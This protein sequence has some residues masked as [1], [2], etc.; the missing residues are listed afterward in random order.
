MRYLWLTGRSAPNFPVDPD[1][2]LYVLYGLKTVYL[3]FD[4][5]GL[6]GQRCEE[7]LGGLYPK[8]KRIVV[9]KGT[10]SPKRLPLPD[11]VQRFTVA[12]EGG[13]YSTQFQA[14]QLEFFSHPR[15]IGHEQRTFVCRSRIQRDPSEVVANHYAGALLIPKRY[16]F[17]ILPSQPV[18]LARSGE[19]LCRTFGI[20]RKCLEFRL[21]HLAIKCINPL[22]IEDARQIPLFKWIAT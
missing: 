13:H 11:E 20:S 14:S 15:L 12:H 3:D 16:L 1:D 2:I 9:H 17:E 8:E 22:W 6:R 19:F 4:I 7:I 10:I 21:K 18:D 5:V